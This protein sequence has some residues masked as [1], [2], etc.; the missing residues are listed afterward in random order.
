[1]TL[2]ALALQWLQIALLCGMT[3]LASSPLRP[4]RRLLINDGCSFWFLVCDKVN[5]DGAQEQP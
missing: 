2:A 3:H 1:V 5:L 4:T